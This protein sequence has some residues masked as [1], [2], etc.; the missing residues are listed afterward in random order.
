MMDQ[1]NQVMN[2]KG[3]DDYRAYA[4]ATF[5]KEKGRVAQLRQRGLLD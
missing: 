4:S 1:L 5:A 2:Y 3:Q